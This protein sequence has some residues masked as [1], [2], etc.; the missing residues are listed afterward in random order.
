MWH[1][2]VANV[3]LLVHLCCIHVCECLWFEGR[4]R[5]R[6]KEIAHRI[7]PCH[8]AHASAMSRQCQL[9]DPSVWHGAFIFVAW[10]S[11]MCEVTHLDVCHDSSIRVKYMHLPHAGSCVQVHVCHVTHPHEWR[12]YK[13]PARTARQFQSHSYGCCDSSTH[14]C[15]VVTCPIACDM[16]HCHA[17]YSHTTDPQQLSNHPY[18]WFNSFT[19]VTWCHDSLG[20]RWQN[21]TD[22]SHLRIIKRKTFN[23]DFLFCLYFSHLFF[24]KRFT[25]SQEK[26]FDP[27]PPTSFLHCLALPLHHKHTHTCM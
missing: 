5:E 17:W 19:R 6:N 14:M 1:G 12:S 27:F 15:D 20:A 3:T 25:F 7:R 4:A 9:A 2:P 24:N 23:V 21:N 13:F 18:V 8:I 22:R 10:C 11:H 26:N 16:T